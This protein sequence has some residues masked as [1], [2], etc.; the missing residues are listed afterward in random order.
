MTASSQK[1]D[2]RDSNRPLGAELPRSSLP[3]F[4]WLLLFAACLAI[5]IGIAVQTGARR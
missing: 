4:V 1:P 3:A 5:L 2:A